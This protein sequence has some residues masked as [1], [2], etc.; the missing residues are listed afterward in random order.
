MCGDDFNIAN[1]NKNTDRT[2]REKITEA[3]EIFYNRIKENG[4]INIYKYFLIIIS[5]ITE[6]LIF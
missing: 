2:I 1:M 4:F 5:F 3:T 6:G